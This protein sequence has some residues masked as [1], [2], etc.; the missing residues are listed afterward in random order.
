MDLRSRAQSLKA[1]SRF[2]QL[3]LLDVEELN[4][5]GIG[6]HELA[7][8][9]IYFIGT[10]LRTIRLHDV[11]LGRN[12]LFLTMVD[13]LSSNLTTLHVSYAKESNLMWPVLIRAFGSQLVEFTLEGCIVD[14]NTEPTL[15]RHL[16]PSCLRRLSIDLSYTNSLFEFCNRFKQLTH[17][18]S[19]IWYAPR[20]KIFDC[21]SNLQS[22]ILN[23][24][25]DIDD[26]DWL[27]DVA[28]K[29]SPFPSLHTLHLEGLIDV[30]Q[31]WM[32][33]FQRFPS[34][35]ELKLSTQ[36]EDQ[37][38][39]CLIH[40]P[41]L[42]ALNAR[43]CDSS[44]SGLS[45]IVLINQ[46]RSLE[47]LHLFW[48]ET[49]F[50]DSAI[51]KLIPMPRVKDFH[52]DTF[53]CLKSFGLGNQM[54]SHLPMLLPSLENLHFKTA[55]WIL[56]HKFLFCVLQLSSLR[57]LRIFT[58]KDQVMPFSRLLSSLLLSKK[59]EFTCLACCN[60]HFG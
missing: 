51:E 23:I 28:R 37:L 2:H 25:D 27:N 44:R 5:N 43:A 6:E 46:M 39:K 30:G 35:T 47:S 14:E 29:C 15:L 41:N 52:F 57:N 12:M 22:L 20:F 58:A 8:A 19:N 10:Q 21:C 7:Q 18:K 4:A 42:V 32:R 3:A 55:H 34:L 54:V 13:H 48:P 38:Y 16:N 33:V 60:M 31:E 49:I 11:D 17:L 36:T 26:V 1:C 59:A 53:E 50:H 9:V 45:A 56:P 40:T 24:D